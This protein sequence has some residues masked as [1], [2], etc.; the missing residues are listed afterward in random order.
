MK[1][2]V[3]E[4]DLN[5]IL[6]GERFSYNCKVCGKIVERKMDK[7]HLDRCMSML[8]MTHLTEKAII[9][10][11]GSLE[12]YKNSRYHKLS[13]IEKSE[14]SAKKDLTRYQNQIIK[15]QSLG[16]EY[17]D[18]LKN[19]ESFLK[20]YSS[21]EKPVI[22]TNET[23]I[24]IE[25]V[26]FVIPSLVI[27]T[28]C[29]CIKCNRPITKRIDSKNIKR[30]D[31]KQF[32]MC[33]HCNQKNTMAI[34]YGDELYSQK[35]A[36][37]KS[38]E[39]LKDEDV[40]RAIVL[41]RKET[42]LKKYGYENGNVLEITKSL[43]DRSKDDKKKTQ[44]KFQKTSISRYGVTHPMKS[45]VI[46]NK[47]R[48]TFIKKYGCWASSSKEVIEKIKATNLEKYG[49]TCS[50]NSVTNRKYRRALYLYNDIKFDSSWE[51]AFYI[52][53]SMLNIEFVYHPS[54][55]II[56][57]VSDQI[58]TYEPDFLVGGRFFEIKGDQ[59]FDEQSHLINPYNKQKLL[60]K[61]NCM[62][63]NNVVILRKTDLEEVFAFIRN[64][65]INLKNFKL[66]K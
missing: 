29:N 16:E 37:Q 54:V 44:E 55:N 57:K 27:Y 25:K 42:N 24:Y 12:E 46:K 14:I 53:L 3:N 1:Y 49:V 64:N 63:E 65:N 60:E 32:F 61:E 2:I 58:H 62:R 43:N 36:G 52:Y 17:V 28:Y 4:E 15:L 34:K 13:K 48:I 35:K 50:M 6:D 8:C 23:F 7:Y 56:Y 5:N 40:K 21:K 18:I 33:M 39:L 30:L 47:L 19:K 41:K 9:E 51:L 11:Y 45:D 66:E 20:S 26:L 31:K 38:K 22:L 59:F 10:K